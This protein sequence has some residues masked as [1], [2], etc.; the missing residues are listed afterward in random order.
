MNRWGLLL[1]LWAGAAG[2]CQSATGP[3]SGLADLRVRVT[4][5]PKEGVATSS[6][7]VQVYDAAAHNQQG[8]F[9][10]LDYASLGNIVVWAEPVL[11]STT[12][13]PIPPLELAVSGSGEG[14][15]SIV[16]A[17]VGQELVLSNRAAHAMDLY[18]V[19]D[20]NDFDLGSVAPGHQGSYVVKSPG[21]IEILTDASEQPLARVYA[22]PA[23]H[24]AVTH[25]GAEVTFSDLLPGDYR[26]R[27]WHP[28][29]PG[30]VVTVHLSADQT[31]SAKITVGVNSL[32]KIDSH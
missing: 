4:A 2:G 21:L 28:R 32:P 14:D 13:Q 16:A 31:Q 11:R 17:C 29:L 27:S 12:H 20:G 10:R 24:V 22:V 7:Q 1:A 30:S 18:S 26:I 3:A 15:D 5:E 9:E 19:S 25:S 6:A 23:R 8:A